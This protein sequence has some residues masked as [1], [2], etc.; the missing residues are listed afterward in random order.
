MG[1]ESLDGRF[2]TECRIIKFA[3]NIQYIIMENRKE[4]EI[5]LL[6]IYKNVY[7]FNTEAEY[8]MIVQKV[9]AMDSKEL[10]MWLNHYKTNGRN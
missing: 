9:W 5:E 6:E 10:S 1:R 3:P 4:K 7:G 2:A 8:W